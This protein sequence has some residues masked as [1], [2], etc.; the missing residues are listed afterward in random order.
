VTAKPNRKVLIEAPFLIVRAF[1]CT[2]LRNTSCVGSCPLQMTQYTYDFC[3]IGRY[4]KYEESVNASPACDDLKILGT[5]PLPV[6][7]IAF[8]Q[9]T[10]R[11]ATEPGRSEV[12]TSVLV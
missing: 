9:R 6:E 3:M 2:P 8:A 11:V 4:Q 12:R 10:R 5:F 7:V 1:F